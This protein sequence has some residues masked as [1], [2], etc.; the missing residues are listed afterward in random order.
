MKIKLTAEQFETV[1]TFLQENGHQ[2]DEYFCYEIGEFQ[3]EFLVYE[4]VDI[5]LQEEY[6]GDLNENEIELECVHKFHL[7]ER[8]VVEYTEEWVEDRDL[9]EFWIRFIGIVGI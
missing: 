4:D 8:R 3:L 2:L 1:K 6:N 7:D 5:E 9:S